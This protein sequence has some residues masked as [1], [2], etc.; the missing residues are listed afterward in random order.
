M[1]NSKKF[2]QIF[3]FKPVYPVPDYVVDQAQSLSDR[4]QV[5]EVIRRGC[6]VAQKVDETGSKG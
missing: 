1:N 4:Q 6:I 5:G 2:E 3:G